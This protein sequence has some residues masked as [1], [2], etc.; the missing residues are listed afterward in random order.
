MIKKYMRKIG[1][2]QAG[3]G[4]RDPLWAREI[5]EVK[6]RQVKEGLA[7]ITLRNKSR[8]EGGWGIRGEKKK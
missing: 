3:D 1:V 5:E 7:R 2:C 6:K 4:I 8:T